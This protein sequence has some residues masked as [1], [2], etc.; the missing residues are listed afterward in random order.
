M[1][2][3]S[4]FYWLTVADKVKEFFDKASN[5]FTFFAVVS[6]IIMVILAIGKNIV[7]ENDEIEVNQEND[8]PKV[9]GWESLKSFTKKLFYISLPLSLVTW[10]GYV[11]TP[12]KKDCLLIVAGGS[13]G[14]FMTTDKAAKEIPSDVAQF[15]H[16]SLREEIQKL[17]TEGKKEIGI[18]TTEKDSLIQKARELSKEELIK[19]IES[20]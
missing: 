10:A 9:K 14:N 18:L 11:L 13:V 3:Y 7:I 2:W 15:L 6:F 8:N 17:G 12:S 5:I 20:N 19:Y 1:N 4:I 16:L